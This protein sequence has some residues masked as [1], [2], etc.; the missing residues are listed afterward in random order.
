MNDGTGEKRA[1]LVVVSAPSGA[2]KT[3]LCRYVTKRH[4]FI[5]LSISCTTRPRRKD[6]RDGRE[7]YFLD[8]KEFFR[9][10]QA[11]DFLE[12]AQVHGHYYGTSSRHV[13]ELLAEGCSVL[14]D[15]DVQGA[16]N[17]KKHYPDAVLVFIAPPSRKELARR[18]KERKTDDPEEIARRLRNAIGET[19][20]ARSYDYIIVN[21]DLAQAVAELEAIATGQAPPPEDREQI[22]NNLMVE[23]GD[24]HET[25]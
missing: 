2:G 15:I 5:R 9:S 16:A 4:P 25:D 24:D 17:L 13:D 18:L 7:Y 14:F 3:T 20:Q 12:W 11:G 22:I 6:E 23:F 21:D 8:E 19:Y 1:R 10:Q